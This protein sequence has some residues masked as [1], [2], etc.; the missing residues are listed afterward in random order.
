V[1]ELERELLRRLNI[2]A[3][4]RQPFAAWQLG[5]RSDTDVECK[6]VK[7][8]REVTILMRTELNALL[9]LLVKKGVFTVEEFQAQMIE[10]ADH[11]SAEYEQKFPGLRAT[12]HGI[13]YDIP[14]AAETMK[15]W[16]P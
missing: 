15:D 13:S 5:T 6:A 14:Q 7:D 4:W 16:K 3:K 11:L 2:L 10:E 8:H 9:G 1:S 12:E